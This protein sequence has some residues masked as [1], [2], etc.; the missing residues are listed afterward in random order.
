[1]Y[2]VIHFELIW[3]Q[4]AT[5]K[6]DG[7]SVLISRI[8]KGSI[9]DQSGLLHEGDEILEINE[10]GIRGKTINDV[11]EFMVRKPLFSLLV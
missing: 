3:L 4:G 2:K 7:E 9:A 6:N 1:M 5:V 11:S 8:V 10:N